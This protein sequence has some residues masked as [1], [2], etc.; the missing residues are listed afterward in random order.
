MYNTCFSGLAQP[1]AW[2][3]FDEFNRMDIEVLSVIAQQI[4][5]VRNAK[6]ARVLVHG[7]RDIQ[8]GLENQRWRVKE[9]FVELQLSPHCLSLTHAAIGLTDKLSNLEPCNYD[10]FTPIKLKPEISFKA[11]R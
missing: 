4:L 3:C 1:G 9:S 11:M 6:L 7:R 2:C 5:T 10:A 8:S